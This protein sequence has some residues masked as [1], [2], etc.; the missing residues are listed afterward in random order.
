ML[1][2]I[3]KS[4]MGD[5]KEGSMVSNI[6]F[7]NLKHLTRNHIIRMEGFKMF[8]KILFTLFCALIFVTSLGWRNNDLASHAVTGNIRI[9]GDMNYQ[10]RLNGTEIVNSKWDKSVNNN[11]SFREGSNTV[12]IFVQ[13]DAWNPPTGRMPG[14]SENIY[15]HIGVIAKI[16]SNVNNKFWVNNGA[17]SEF[18]TNGSWEITKTAG[19]G[20][21]EVVR[22]WGKHPW[23]IKHFNDRA[24]NQFKNSNAKWI[25]VVNPA[26]NRINL[27]NTKF[28]ITKDFI[29]DTT[30]PQ[31]S[32]SPNS[33][34]WTS[35][36]VSVTVNR[37]DPNG[38]GVDRWRYRLSSN[39]GG[40]Y[41]NWSAYNPSGTINLNSSGQWKIRVEIS[42][43][44]GNSR[45]Y[46]SGTYNIDKRPTPSITLN[47]VTKAFGDNAF[48][49]PHRTNSDGSK[50]FSSSNTSVATIT[51]TGV[52]TIR[53][54]GSSTIRLNVS[55]TSNFK[56]GSNTATLTVNKANQAALTISPSSTHTFNTTRTYTIGGGSGTGAVTDSLVSGSATRTAARTYRANAG[57]GTYTIRVTKAG[58]SNYNPRTQDFTFTM[59]KANQAALTI[60]PSSTHTF[61]TTRTY[62][63][64][65]GSGTGAVSDSLVSGSATRTAARTYRANAGSGTYTIRVTKAGDSNYNPRT[66]DF[67]FTMVKANQA[68][69]TISP[70]STHTFNTTRTYTIGGGSGTG[71]VSDSLV[72]GSATRTAAR[73]Y[74]ANAGNGTY[75]IRVTKAGD[76]NYNPR[77]QDFTFTM[78]KANQAALT[79][80]PSSTHTFNTTRTYTIGGGSGTGAVSD[81]LAS[82]SATRTAARTYKANA[83]NVELTP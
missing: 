82:G 77:T 61:N 58:D 20:T 16:E 8:K 68:A 59:V 33:S 24:N 2:I 27:N 25:G 34:G 18:V 55:E 60:S 6:N 54:A 50:T 49:I 80:S 14:L 64:G 32:F 56:A 79:I 72:S 76:S 30:P 10:V 11:V 3:K 65:G 73:T 69:L 9:V 17:R 71:A 29:V 78:V 36:N 13:N 53:G 26:N 21:V 81:S 83:G 47:N 63:I 39:N 46:D 70:S 28:Y 48:T 57:S 37:S 4:S 74:R 35:N 19:N 45:V 75:T 22:D 23:E 41:G 31:A 42:D 12:R 15:N 38:S 67:T 1:L 40:S 5:L 44:V 62:T 66:Q 51:N 7:L 43:K 52:V